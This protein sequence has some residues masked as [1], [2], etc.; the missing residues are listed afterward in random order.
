MARA[1]LIL[2]WLLWP[3]RPADAALFT[4]GVTCTVSGRIER[5]PDGKPSFARRDGCRMIGHRLEGSDLLLYSLDHWV[6]I[7]LPR[8]TDAHPFWYHWSAAHAM[9]GGV[10]YRVAWGRVDQPD[11]P[12]AVGLPSALPE[13]S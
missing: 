10:G 2:L 8:R 9:V 13:G 6:L 11:R 3:G 1:L 5:G 7:R 12:E 4:G